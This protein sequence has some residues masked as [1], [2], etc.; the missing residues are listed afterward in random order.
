GV[1]RARNL[2][3]VPRS[4]RELRVQ[5]QLR[6]GTTRGDDLRRAFGGL[7]DGRTGEVQLDRGDA[8]AGAEDGAR[9]CILACGEAADGDPDRRV[10][11]ARELR[12][13]PAHEQV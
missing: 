7:I 4:G 10:H 2:R 1:D 12:Q 6:R 11:G 3:D 9:L 13:D 8:V 5:R